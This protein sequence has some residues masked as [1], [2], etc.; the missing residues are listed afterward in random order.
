MIRLISIALALLLTACTRPEITRYDPATYT[1][2]FVYP[3]PLPFLQVKADG[4]SQIVY[5][6]DPDPKHRSVLRIRGI[7]GDASL[8]PVFQD[9][10][11]LTSAQVSNEGASAALQNLVSAIGAFAKS[12][13]AVGTLYGREDATATLVPGLY[14]IDVARMR[15]VGPMAVAATP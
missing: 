2:G 8:S 6:P 9:G 5:L 3:R 14:R 1:D 10:W 11:N 13:F 7:I 15:L 12:G 4:T